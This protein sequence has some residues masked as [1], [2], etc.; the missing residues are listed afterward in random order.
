MYHRTHRPTR[1]DMMSNRDE[2]NPN[3]SDLLLKYM[4]SSKKIVGHNSHPMTRKQTSIIDR[5]DRGCLGGIRICR[6]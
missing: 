6:L 5:N 4:R 1:D 3:S 2:V